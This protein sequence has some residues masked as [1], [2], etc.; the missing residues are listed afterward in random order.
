MEGKTLG[1]GIKQRPAKR[2]IRCLKRFTPTGANCKR[3]APC[4]QEHHLEV[5]KERWQ[6]TYVKKG[7][8]QAGAN[9]NAWAGG[10]S[11]AYYRKVAFEAHGDRC[12]RCRDSAVL[13]HHK[14]GNRSNSAV[15]NLE[16]LC[17]R[18]H[19]LEHDCASNLPNAKRNSR[20]A[21]A[22]A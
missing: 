15:D 1:M 8:T 22:K 10:R 13:V 12:L 17:K 2:C 5:C 9:N 20:S 21:H 16:P 3:C 4:R 11:P 7:Y 14:D 6:R 19:Q 18:C